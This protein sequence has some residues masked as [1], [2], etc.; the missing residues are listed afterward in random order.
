MRKNY[1]FLFVGLFVFITLSSFAFEN[2]YFKVN[3]SKWDEIKSNHKN[4]FSF[5]MKDY[6]PEDPM[7]KMF[8][9]TITI[10]V[11][12]NPDGKNHYI[13]NE[14]DYLENYK[15]EFEKDFNESTKKV[16]ENMLK[17]AM[18]AMPNSTKSQ[19]EKMVEKEYDKFGSEMGSVSYKKLGKHKGFEGNYKITTFNF[20]GIKV[21]TLTKTFIIEIKYPE[22]TDIDSLPAYKEFIS[23]L[24]FKDKEATKFNAETMPLI[25]YTVL[26]LIGVCLGAVIVIYVRKNNY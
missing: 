5:Q 22:L 21:L 1:Y 18:Q 3:T 17:I 25:I 24:D 13:K 19:L 16:K 14:K 7:M 6:E 11:K 8:P 4:I 2:E 15:K 12:P 10:G 20:K 9:P 23:S 26:G